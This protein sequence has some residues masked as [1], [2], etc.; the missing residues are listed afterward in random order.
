[1]VNSICL[2]SHP[3]SKSSLAKF[4][5]FS[6]PR[7]EPL[8]HSIWISFC[9]PVHLFILRERESQAGSALCASAPP[10]PMRGS[11]Q[12]TRETTTGAQIKSWTFKFNRLSHPVPTHPHPGFLNSSWS[13]CSA[14]ALNIA[15]RLVLLKHRYIMY[16]PLL[17]IRQGFPARSV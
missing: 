8:S 14:P 13:P 1:M 2:I 10:F 15:A 12:R 16:I 4:N 6:P 5:Y 7:V 17:Q 9:F 11:T 3:V